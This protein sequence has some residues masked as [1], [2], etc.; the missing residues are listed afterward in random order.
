[1]S[2]RKFLKHLGVTAQLQIEEAV[3]RSGKT[4]GKIPV[5]GRVVAPEIGLDHVIEGE[6]DLD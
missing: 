6:L 5:T 1:M 2:L 3:R 4:S